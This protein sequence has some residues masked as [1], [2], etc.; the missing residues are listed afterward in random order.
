MRETEIYLCQGQ[1]VSSL[2]IDK[3]HYFLTWTKIDQKMLDSVQLESS[4]FNFFNNIKNVE[5]NFSGSP[6]TS[7]FCLA[8]DHR[9]AVCIRN[10]LRFEFSQNFWQIKRTSRADR[11][12]QQATEPGG[13][14]ISRMASS[15]ITLWRKDKVRFATLKKKHILALTTVMI[16]QSSPLSAIKLVDLPILTWQ[17]LT[18]FTPA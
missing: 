8:Y 11:N 3:W 4:A 16:A 6:N 10:R 17:T 14:S 5:I 1:L 9:S 15:C 7:N 13:Q 2:G 18:T 12:T